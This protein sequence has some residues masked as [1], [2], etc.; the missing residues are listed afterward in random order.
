MSI[1]RTRYLKKEG[2]K[3][4]KQ[5]R[6]CRAYVRKFL[7]CNYIFHIRNYA[8]NKKILPYEWNHFTETI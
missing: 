3:T 4:K 1:I 2:V 7:K 6:E 5:K 8:F